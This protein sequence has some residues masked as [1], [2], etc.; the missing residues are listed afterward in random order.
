MVSATV[1][2][3]LAT[4]LL[5]GAAVAK[6]EEV[7]TI[8][9][10]VDKIF[11]DDDFAK[12]T[13]KETTADDRKKRSAT[14]VG[15]G[16]YDNDIDD[17]TVYGNGIYGNGCGVTPTQN[18]NFVRCFDPRST[19]VLRSGVVRNYYRQGNYGQCLNYFNSLPLGNVSPVTGG[20]TGQLTAG[21]GR[22]YTVN[23][24]QRC[25]GGYPG[26]RVAGNSPYNRGIIRQFIFRPQI[27]RVNYSPYATGY[28]TGYNGAGYGTGYVNGA[29]YGAG[30][31]NGGDY[32]NDAGYV[33]GVGYTNGAGYVNGAGLVNDAGYLNG[34]GYYNGAGYV[35]GGGYTNGAGYVNSGGY[36]NGA[37]YVSGA[38]FLNGGGGGYINGGG[39][40][41]GLSDGGNYV[42][43]VGTGNGL[44][45]GGLVDSVVGAPG[46]VRAPGVVGAAANVGC[47]TDC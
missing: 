16:V 2:C 40:S 27:N 32:Y 20:Y 28:G 44:T 30:Y 39:Y 31:V 22:S 35:N 38:G 36:T 11:A 45:S 6:K 12:V 4:V 24:C 33:N 25:Y 10:E 43:V 1:T 46:V 21:S 41:S 13:T 47:N 5:V 8:F 3:I 29:G 7:K 42:N 17:S 15:N 9:E 26:I 14:H 23:A 34:A 18:V 19:S 37:G